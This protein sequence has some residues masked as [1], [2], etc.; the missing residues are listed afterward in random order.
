[1]K[2]TGAFAKAKIRGNYITALIKLLLENVFIN[3]KLFEIVKEK[4]KETT[5]ASK[6]SKH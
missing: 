6:E 3:S 1:M 2:V 5:E 4:V